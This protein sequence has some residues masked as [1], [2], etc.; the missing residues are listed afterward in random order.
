MVDWSY[1]DTK[2]PTKL[3]K[4][5]MTKEEWRKER[6]IEL[7]DYLPQTTLEE[8]RT[9]TDIRDAVIELNYTFF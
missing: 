3:N 2:Y 6:T 1:I 5:S 8:R 9:Y 4:D 7:Y